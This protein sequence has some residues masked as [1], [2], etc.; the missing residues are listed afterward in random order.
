MR[1]RRWKSGCSCSEWSRVVDWRWLNTPSSTVVSGPSEAVERWVRRLGEEGVFSR[2]VQVDH[3]SHSAEM[4][5]IWSEFG[6]WRSSVSCAA[7][8]AGADRDDGDGARCDGTA[9]D[10]EYWVPAPAAD[11]AFLDLALRS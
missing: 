2:Q 6:K 1:S 8:R 5:P 11:G 7:G 3:A 9:L 4:D 10:A